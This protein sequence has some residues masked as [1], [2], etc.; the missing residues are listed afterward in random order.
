MLAVVLTV[1]FIKE[2]CMMPINPIIAAAV[3]NMAVGIFWYS[4]Y[5]FGPLWMNISGKKKSDISANIYQRLALQVLSSVITVTALYIAIM[6][7]QKTHG[8]YHQELF[9]KWFS[10]LLKESAAPTTELLSS[11]KATGFI[12]LGFF[13]PHHLACTAWSTL[14]NWR[15]LAIHAGA[16]LASLLAAAAVLATLA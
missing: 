9:T 16:S 2:D 4:D 15:M 5:A 3:A 10:W 13:L 7:F 6:T 12:W 14:I 1:L 8:A 11:M